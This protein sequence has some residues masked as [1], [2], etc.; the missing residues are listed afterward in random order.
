MFIRVQWLFDASD[1]V[2]SSVYMEETLNYG[3]RMKLVRGRAREAIRVANR[4]RSN[5]KPRVLVY[6]R[7]VFTDTRNYLSE[8]SFNRSSVGKK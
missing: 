3:D 5:V 1:I 8:V 7:Y 6:H 2:Y 4:A